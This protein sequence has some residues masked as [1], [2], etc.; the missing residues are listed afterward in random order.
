MDLTI[1]NVLLEKRNQECLKSI[2][3]SILK[4]FSIKN[5][6]IFFYQTKQKSKNEDDFI[7]HPI[8]Y[9]KKE[10]G[11]LQISTENIVDLKRLSDIDEKI[12]LLINRYITNKIS[13]SFL[14]NVEKLI[15]TS[16]HILNIENFIEKSSNSKYPVI[17]KGKYGCEKL[18]VASAIHYYSD[19]SETEFREI[20]CNSINELSLKEELSNAEKD[21]KNGTLYLSE[22]ENLNIKQQHII[23]DF[24][25]AKSIPNKKN[26]IRY[27]I[28]S[29]KDLYSEVKNKNFSKKLFENF[30]F[31]TIEIPSLKNRKEDIPYMINFLLFENSLTKEIFFSDEVI[32]ALISY[33][34]P[35]NY[36]E[37][38]R[39]VVKLITF[40]N[41]KEITI[42]DVE[43]N[44]PEIL[45]TQ[46]NLENN[47]NLIDCLSQNNYQC[48]SFYHK[49]LQRSLDYISKNFNRN[50]SLSI[51]SN[52]ACVSPSHLSYL[53]RSHLGRSFK[54]IITELRIKKIKEDFFINPN[55]KITEASLDMGFG[56]LSHF[57]KMFKRYT[58]LTPRDYKKKFKYN[59]K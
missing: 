34:W 29:N 23:I 19:K 35:G 5:V 28:S 14:G 27:I 45:C 9:K 3:Y 11:Y 8:F 58:G 6:N 26:N 44:T 13:N 43:K 52:E 41:N 15:G 4:K 51:L 37:F 33:E 54:E 59:L 57:E 36:K 20:N 42:D 12:N 24:L 16:E 22:I 17:I 7:I 2:L 39:V 48:E 30:N 1:N 18:A 40:S 10:I 55:K 53:F 56:D 32:H 47:N 21:I 38:E 31:L 25:C 46:Y 50:I 49:G